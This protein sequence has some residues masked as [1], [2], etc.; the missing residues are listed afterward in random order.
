MYCVYNKKNIM[1][2]IVVFI[3]ISDFTG[4]MLMVV[5]KS[6]TKLPITWHNNCKQ[7]W[8][9]NKMASRLLWRICRDDH[10]PVYSPHWRRCC[11][12]LPLWVKLNLN[13]FVLWFLRSLGLKIVRWQRR[14]TYLR[15][16]GIFNLAAILASS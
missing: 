11:G 9:Y 10:R 13:V 5:H 4:K 1:L 2:P 14:E 7:N 3:I 12:G 6:I 8:Q 15:R 16:E